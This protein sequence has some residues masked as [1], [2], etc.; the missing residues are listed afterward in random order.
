MPMTTAAGLPRKAAMRSSSSRC[1]S[2]VP[3]SERADELLTPSLFSCMCVSVHVCVCVC[4]SV[5][6]CVRERENVC[7][8]V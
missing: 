8:R 1:T 4:V 2:V 7:V 6:V 3:S 5:C